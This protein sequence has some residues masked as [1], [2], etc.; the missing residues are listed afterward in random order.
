MSTSVDTVYIEGRY[1]SILDDD[2]FNSLP[3]LLALQFLGFAFS[4]QGENSLRITNERLNRIREALDDVNQAI[5]II[6][7]ETSDEGNNLIAEPDKIALVESVL[8][9][10]GISYQKDS[11]GY[12]KI[13]EDEVWTDQLQTESTSLSN[14]LQRLITQ[15]QSEG[16]RIEQ[17]NSFGESARQTS[18]TVVDVLLG[19][20]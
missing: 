3:P 5:A 20:A 18:D 10:Y 1:N 11:D 6:Q 9:E 4:E 15:A 7:F 16:S 17:G 14:E 2:N 8:K 13:P 19:R 12:I